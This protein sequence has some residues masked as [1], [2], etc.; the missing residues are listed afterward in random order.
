MK[1][2]GIYDIKD[3]CYHDLSGG[4]QQRVLLARA[5]CATKKVILLDEPVAGLD[6]VVT[7]ELYELIASINKNMGI[8]VIMVSHD[9][10]ATLKYAS[11][12][13][14]ISDE[15]AFFGTKEE[16]MKSK[17]FEKLTAATNRSEGGF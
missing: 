5:M 7:A 11:H 6:P 8:T 13:L 9:M 4:Q 15:T 14:Y 16:Y 10:E 1:L 12:I 3:K 17:G 2:M